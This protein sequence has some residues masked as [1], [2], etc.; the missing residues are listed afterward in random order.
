MA[1]TSFVTGLLSL[2]IAN[3]VFGPC[4]IAL[5]AAALVRGTVRRFRARLGMALGA[6]GLVLFVALAVADGTP[7]WHL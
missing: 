5:G 6:V 4:A 3:L 7:S 1:V 2:L